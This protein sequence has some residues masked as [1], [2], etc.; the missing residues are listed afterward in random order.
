MKV[1]RESQSA[2]VAPEASSKYTWVP[3]GLTD[4][5]VEQYFSMIPKEK[6]PLVDSEGARYRVTQMELQLPAHDFDAA[7]VKAIALP[8]ERE[9]FE[10]FCV[11]KVED[12]ADVGKVQL[13][14]EKRPC[15]RC[16][17]SFRPGD[18]AVSCSRID[19]GDGT[20]ALFHHDTCFVCEVC[21][22][23]LVDLMAFVYDGDRLLCGRHYA[24]MYKPR[25]AACDESIMAKDFTY[26]EEQ[27]WHENHFCCV[28]CDSNLADAEY[29]T[30]NKQPVCIPCHDKANA[31]PCA[32]CG[33]PISVAHGRISNG[34]GKH[35]HTACFSCAACG[36]NLQG[37]ACFPRDNQL[38]C[39]EDYY[40][41]FKRVERKSVRKKVKKKSYSAGHKDM[42][43]AIA[44]E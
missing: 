39:R 5:L 7:A 37:M 8:E 6:V 41:K 40:T 32:A 27:C 26:A 2:L 42:S 34:T 4:E 24:D 18:L 43:H 17:A 11:K 21:D 22:E 25:C 16:G 14:K 13:M 3:D 36:A 23:G 19:S 44:E 1:R 9:L 15:F 35:W 33:K 29:V 12:G 38:Y 30:V 20:P 28:E 31:V 10:S